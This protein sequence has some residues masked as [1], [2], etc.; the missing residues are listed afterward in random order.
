MDS[1]YI[2]QKYVAKIS[3]NS[4]IYG[5]F[6]PLTKILHFSDTMV[7][8]EKG[9]GAQLEIVDMKNKLQNQDVPESVGW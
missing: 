6:S 4:L 1:P 3:G 8:G 5:N 2:I 9:T 7:I